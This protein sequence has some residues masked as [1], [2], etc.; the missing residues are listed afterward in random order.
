MKFAV[1]IFLRLIENCIKFQT[2]IEYNL[3]KII[4]GIRNESL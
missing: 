1:H 2:N 4:D 3:N